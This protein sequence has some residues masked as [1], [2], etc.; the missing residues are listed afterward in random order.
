MKIRWVFF[1]GHNFFAQTR[2]AWR[3]FAVY[4]LA[5]ADNETPLPISM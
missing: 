5:G 1:F 2:N 3:N 4:S